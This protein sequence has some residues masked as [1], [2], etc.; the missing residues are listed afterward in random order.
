MN[1]R[2]PRS[3]ELKYSERI[4]RCKIINSTKNNIIESGKRG[5]I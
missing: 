4:T 1:S 3:E 2:S 5:E